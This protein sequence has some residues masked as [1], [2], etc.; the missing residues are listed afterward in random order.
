MEIPRAIPAIAI[1][2]ISEEKLDELLYHI[3]FEMNYEKFIMCPMRLNI[4]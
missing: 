1:L 2:F 4:R 3:L